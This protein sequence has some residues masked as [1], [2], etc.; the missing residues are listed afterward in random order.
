MEL[1]DRKRNILRAI[2]DDYIETAE[3]VGS[4][5]IAKK[6]DMGIS[7]ATIRNEMS[8]LEDL[9]YLEQPHTSSGRIPSDLGYR[10]YVNQLMDVSYPLPEEIEAI[11]HFMKLVAANEVDKIIKRTTR[12][13]SQIT[14]YTS[15]LL[16]PSVNRS[17]VRSI[18]LIRVTSR[19]VVAVVVTDTG[20][21]KNVV[22]R[23]PEEVS[24]ESVAKISN[25]LNEKLF[26][27]T[28]E[29]IGLSI[30]SSIQTEMKGHSELFNA[31]I[32]VLYESLRAEDS[33]IYLEGT[34]NIFNYPEY[35]DREKAVNFLSMVEQKDMLLNLL[36]D[37]AENVSI[38]IGKENS[39]KEVKDCSIIKAAYRIGNKPAG[40]IGII[41][42]TRMN[43]SR[44]IGVLKCLSDTLN[45]I[46]KSP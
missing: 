13:L 16:T 4:R 19:D 42:P 31:I 28:I 1:G 17:S 30:I 15:V 34:T 43:Y 24:S 14:Q 44:V 25:M 38:S 11:K 41:G 33:E 2:I 5:T 26:G 22:I 37:E 40:A 8:D 36:S 23:L 29:D 45:D 18:Q 46:L 27:L 12:L 21:I 6:Y 32:P 20:M 35:N 3:P 7:S 10:T 9:G 39:F